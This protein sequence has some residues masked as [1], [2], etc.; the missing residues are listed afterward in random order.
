MLQCRSHLWSPKCHLRRQDPRHLHLPITQSLGKIT[1]MLQMWIL[2]ISRFITEI[3]AGLMD[4]LDAESLKG[5]CMGK[6]ASMRHIWLGRPPK[7]KRRATG[8][9]WGCSQ[10]AA[11]SKVMTSRPSVCA[12]VCVHVLQSP[13]SRRAHS[14]RSF[15]GSGIA[16][17]GQAL[18]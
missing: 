4:G 8:Q 6:A 10:L 9:M 18:L 7:R 2:G 13:V 16:V 14:P 5:A 17:G 1:S 12:R 15:G 11:P 3:L